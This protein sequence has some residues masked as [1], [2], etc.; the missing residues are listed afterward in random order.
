MQARNI[1]Y[2]MVFLLKQIV[3]GLLTVSILLHF[4]M[5]HKLALAFLSTIRFLFYVVNSL[6]KQS[7]K[8]AFYTLSQ[9]KIQIRGRILIFLG[10]TS[11]LNLGIIKCLRKEQTCQFDQ[12]IQQSQIV[13]L[14]NLSRIV[15]E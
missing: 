5:M 2:H 14:Q 8:V 12:E 11:Y 13:Q 7:F 10:W 3:Q 9:D 4:N 15:H 1:F 6:F